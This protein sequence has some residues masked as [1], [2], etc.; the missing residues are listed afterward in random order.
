MI[1]QTANQMTR[2]AFQLISLLGWS[3]QAAYHRALDTD[4]VTFTMPLKVTTAP[5]A[6]DGITVLL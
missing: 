1:T 2:E 5:S 3:C 6:A 4:V